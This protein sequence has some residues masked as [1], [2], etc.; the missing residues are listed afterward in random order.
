MR[1]DTFIPRRLDDAWKIGLWD[2]DV[3]APTIFMMMVGLATR[4]L[5]GFSACAVLGIFGSRHISRIKADK[6][7]SLAL[8]WIH[9]HLPQTPF[10]RLRATPPSHRRHMI[11]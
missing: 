2:A 10:T 11:G 4:D 7:P 1:T 9:W 6:H 8:H 3:A 5:W